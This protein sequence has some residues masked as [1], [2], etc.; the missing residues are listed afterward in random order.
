MSDVVAKQL[1]EMLTAIGESPDFIAYRT[2]AATVVPNGSE[3]RIT[4]L[5]SWLDAFD[6]RRFSDLFTQQEWLGAFDDLCLYELKYDHHETSFVLIFDPWAFE[7]NR[8]LLRYARLS[9]EERLDLE[10]SVP[11]PRWILA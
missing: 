4:R 8:E 9:A 1:R 6:E 5:Q 7:R 11:N 2:A 10:A 3:L